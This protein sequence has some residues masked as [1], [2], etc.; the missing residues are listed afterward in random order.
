MRPLQVHYS[1]EKLFVQVS[2]RRVWKQ[3]HQVGN[4]ALAQK[5]TRWKHVGEPA[6]SR[7][8]DSWRGTSVRRASER[9][10]NDGEEAAFALSKPALSATEGPR[11]SVSKNRRVQSRRSMKGK[12]LS[13]TSCQEGTKREPS[14]AGHLPF[15]LSWEAQGGVLAYRRTPP[16]YQVRCVRWKTVA[17]PTP[18]A[19]GTLLALFNVLHAEGLSGQ[20]PEPFD[21]V[22]PVFAATL[23]VY[24]A[25]TRSGEFDQPSRHPDGDV[26]P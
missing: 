2:T 10:L 20:T 17:R 15:S 24:A 18:A 16:A 9:D 19:E 8:Q 21:S 12:A 13:T 25:G 4:P 5:Q 26:H 14:A 3:A 7:F 6:N 23:E 11:L 22:D 1:I